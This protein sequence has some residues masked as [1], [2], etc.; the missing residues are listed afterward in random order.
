MGER[1]RYQPYGERNEGR[2]QNREDRNR[3][4]DWRAQSRDRSWNERDDR[5]HS[6]DYRQDYEG[7]YGLQYGDRNRAPGLGG[8]ESRR[9]P[10]TF[11]SP[12]DQ[13]YGRDWSRDRGYEST[14]NYGIYGSQGDR[15]RGYYSRDRNQGF[16]S[17]DGQSFGRGQSYSYGG[18]YSG[19]VGDDR[20]RDEDRDH[21]EGLGQQLR[22]AGQRFIGKVKRVFRAPKGYKRSDERIR[23]DVNDRLG[24]EQHL[25]PS[26]IEVQVSNAE[27]TLTGTVESRREKFLAEE[28]A[29]DVGGVTEVHNQL[30]VRRA[31]TQPAAS[32]D[33]TSSLGTSGTEASR[34]RN[35]RAQ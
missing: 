26:E 4:D 19:Y 22:E 14:Y 6:R 5:D 20:N 2:Y 10:G 31:Q 24:H 35:A 15:D 29:D 9:F 13:R 16:G 18:S 12:E 33:T 30:R 34:T 28:I 25:D 7:N 3:D 21:E 23:E 1:D 32:T 27:V 11:G 8:Y 17:S